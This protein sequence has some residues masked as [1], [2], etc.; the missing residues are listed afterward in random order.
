MCYIEGTQQVGPY[1]NMPSVYSEG[2]ETHDSVQE[3]A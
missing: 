1:R 2:C 3:A